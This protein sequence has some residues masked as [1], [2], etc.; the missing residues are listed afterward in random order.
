LARLRKQFAVE[1]QPGI[2]CVVEFYVTLNYIK[3]LSVA[4]QCFYGKFVTGNNAFVRTS[5]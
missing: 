5:F 3:I 1:A 4:Q 2:V